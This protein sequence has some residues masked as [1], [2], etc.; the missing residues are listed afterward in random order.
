MLFA[1]YIVSEWRFDNKLFY[2]QGILQCWWRS[3][4][5]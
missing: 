4:D 2:L 3:S 1:A 5:W